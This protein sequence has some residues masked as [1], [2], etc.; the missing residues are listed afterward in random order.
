MDDIDDVHTVLQG[1]STIATSVHRRPSN[2][3]KAAE[4]ESVYTATSYAQSESGY[5]T[6]TP[7]PWPDNARDGQMF[8]CP[9]CFYVIS[10]VC[11]WSHH[12]N[13]RVLLEPQV[14]LQA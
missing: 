13:L 3:P 8:V 6:L 7:P 1:P 4:D 2:I 12:F 14:V 9:L 11:Q 5:S 10:T